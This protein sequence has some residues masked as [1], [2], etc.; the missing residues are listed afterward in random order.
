MQASS[1]LPVTFLQATKEVFT[2][3]GEGECE[4]IHSMWR[5]CRPLPPLRRVPFVLAKG[6]KTAG[7]R[8][9]PYAALRVPSL[10]CLPGASRPTTCCAKSTAREL[11]LRPKGAAHQPPPD[12]STRPPEV[13]KLLAAPALAYLRNRCWR[14]QTDVVAGQARLLSEYRLAPDLDLRARKFRRCR[15]RL[16]EAERRYL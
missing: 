14:S 5:C 7:S 16:Q 10:R 9:R 3:F 13:A 1:F 2:G 4:L 8:I 6:T 11:R 15:L 12:T